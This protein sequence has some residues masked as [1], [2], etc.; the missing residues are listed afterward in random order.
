MENTMSEA[1]LQ[2][3]RADRRRC[4]QISPPPYETS[5]GKVF[6]DRRSAI[7]RRASWIREFSLDAI[8]GRNS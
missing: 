3:R 1:A 7:D 4:T 5:S 2:R 8:N 6:T